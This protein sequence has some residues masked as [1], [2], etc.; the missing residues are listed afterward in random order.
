MKSIKMEQNNGYGYTV[1]SGLGLYYRRMASTG[2]VVF[3]SA[4][5][6]TT[7]FLGRTSHS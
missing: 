2:G 6:G 3:D 7:M 5:D 4:L 1:S